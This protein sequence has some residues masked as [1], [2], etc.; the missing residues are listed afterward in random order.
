MSNT[1]PIRHR[2]IR[3]IK[4]DIDEYDIEYDICQIRRRRKRHFQIVEFDNI[5]WKLLKSP[6]VACT[7]QAADACQSTKVAIAFNEY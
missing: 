2:R 7:A 3:H 6:H 5:I 1:T 4:N